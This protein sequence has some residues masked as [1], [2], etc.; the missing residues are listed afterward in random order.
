M[1]LDPRSV[2]N[3][4]IDE[5]RRRGTP[6]TNLSL[7]KILYFI[8][9]RYLVEKNAPL[10]SGFFEAWQYG[11]VHPLIYDAFKH[12]G[13]SPLLEVAQK[14]DL[15]TGAI[16]PIDAPTDQ[17]IVQWISDVASSYIRLSPG[18]LVELSH[19]NESPWDILTKCEEGGR[20][21]GLRITHE[22][23][24]SRFKHHKVSIDEFPRSGEPNEE[25]P[26]Y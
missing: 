21:F 9:G 4:V 13:A 3:L 15:M 19:A 8:Q 5:A 18:R 16:K 11:P 22:M 1:P 24:R 2:A 12:K 23:I 7:Q 20:R 6:V 14:R 25:S 17:H 10:M 26:P